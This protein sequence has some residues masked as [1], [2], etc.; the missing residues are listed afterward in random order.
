MATGEVETTFLG[1]VLSTYALQASL[2]DRTDQVSE[3]SNDRLVYPLLHVDQNDGDEATR[4]RNE[5]SQS[6]PP[7]RKDGK[8]H[9]T[10]P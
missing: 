2:V 8:F 5:V 1:S 7:R 4:R 9:L 6:P 10:A 3:I